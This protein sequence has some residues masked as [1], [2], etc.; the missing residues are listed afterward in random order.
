MESVAIAVLERADFGG[1]NTA[2]AHFKKDPNFQPRTDVSELKKLEGSI[3]PDGA[4]T[5]LDIACINKL[6][7]VASYICS[8]E[9]FVEVNNISPGNYT[10]LMHAVHNELP[11]AGMGN[12]F[13]S[14][15]HCLSAWDEHVHEVHLNA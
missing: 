4:L 5:A 1:I 2:E 6:D 15:V 8:R 7:D 11:K 3:V 10:S 14:N 12:S 13:F 9:D